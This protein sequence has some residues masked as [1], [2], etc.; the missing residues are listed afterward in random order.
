MNLNAKLYQN[1]SNVGL[2]HRATVSVA[3]LQTVLELV[4]EDS[5]RTQNR[6]LGL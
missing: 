2:L 5:S 1:L 4:L 6:G 3:Q